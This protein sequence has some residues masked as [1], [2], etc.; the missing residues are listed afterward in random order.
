ML[1]MAQFKGLFGATLYLH[2]V[3][4]RG[5]MELESAPAF[6]AYASKENLSMLKSVIKYEY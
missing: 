1:S 4:V 5:S 6:K 3:M 2:P